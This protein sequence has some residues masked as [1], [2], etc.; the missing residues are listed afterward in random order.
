MMALLGLLFVLGALELSFLVG[1]EVGKL[2]AARALFPRLLV[3]VGCLG[4]IALYHFVQ[5][6]VSD[7]VLHPEFY[8]LSPWLAGRLRRLMLPKRKKEFVYVSV[9]R[10]SNSL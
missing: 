7:Y 8:G 1:R 5:E 4:N 3:A 2:E 6:W 9:N 10:G